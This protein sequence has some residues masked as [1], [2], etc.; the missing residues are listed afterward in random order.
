MILL[1][2][3]IIVSMNQLM[4]AVQQLHYGDIPIILL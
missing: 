1:K 3:I 4:N 2:H